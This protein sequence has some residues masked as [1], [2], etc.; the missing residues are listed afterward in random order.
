MRGRVG[1]PE[2]M[3]SHTLKDRSPFVTGYLTH[4]LRQLTSLF[5][6][7]DL[8]QLVLLL[9]VSLSSCPKTGRVYTPTPLGGRELCA[10]QRGFAVVLINENNGMERD[11]ESCWGSWEP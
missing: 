6:A 11:R 9:C 1:E 8:G 7:Y 5:P 3:G 2:T 10:W 4:C